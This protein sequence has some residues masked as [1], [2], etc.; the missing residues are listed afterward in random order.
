MKKKELEDAKYN[1]DLKQT[2]YANLFWLVWILI[3]TWIIVLLVNQV[4]L[5]ENEINRLLALLIIC[6]STV[7]LV[8]WCGSPHVHFKE[9]H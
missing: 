6:F 8:S 2:I 7:R 4:E 3:M 5:L 9:K 1:V